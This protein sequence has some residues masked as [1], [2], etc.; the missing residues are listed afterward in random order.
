VGISWQQVDDGGGGLAGAKQSSGKR[1][2]GI[3][4]KDGRE[5][6]RATPTSFKM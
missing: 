1:K 2:G 5:R 6:D 4:R 3:I